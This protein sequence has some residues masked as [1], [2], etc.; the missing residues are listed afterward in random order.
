MGES[1]PYPPVTVA[2][3]RER[4]MTGAF[5]FIGGHYLRAI[6]PDTV[7]IGVLHT[8]RI[9]CLPAR[10]VVL[11]GFN[12]PNRDLA[13]TLAAQ[14]RAVHL[15]GDVLGGN[16]IMTAIHGAAELGRRL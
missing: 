13:D 5:D 11:V 2:A 9:R 16:G 15:I 8:D 4:L 7:E 14:G 10:T 12:V 1:L 6:T 3:A